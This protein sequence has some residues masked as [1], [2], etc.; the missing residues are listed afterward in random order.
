MNL[1][2]FCSAMEG[3]ALTEGCKSTE[4]LQ[5]SKWSITLFGFRVQFVPRK[6]SKQIVFLD[7]GNQNDARLSGSHVGVK[8]FLRG[9]SLMKCLSWLTYSVSGQLTKEF[10]IAEARKLQS[11]AWAR[12]TKK[13]LNSEQKNIYRVLCS[14]PD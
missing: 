7:G 6:T 13:A 2:N 8:L 11:F 3:R 5:L 12:S 4:Y 9:L 14:L 1:V 10:L